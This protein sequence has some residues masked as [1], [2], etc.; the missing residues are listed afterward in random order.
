MLVFLTAELEVIRQPS[1]VTLRQVPPFRW[2]TK[3]MKDGLI[4]LFMGGV[5]RCAPVRLF[6][7]R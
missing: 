4:N 5:T 3:K 6:G 1:Q 7:L 2:R